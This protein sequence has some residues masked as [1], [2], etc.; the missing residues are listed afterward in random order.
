MALVISC[1]NGNAQNGIVGSRVRWTCTDCRVRF[2]HLSP[3][4]GPAGYYE[5]KH[6]GGRYAEEYWGTEATASNHQCLHLDI[7]LSE[8]VSSYIKEV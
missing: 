4:R 2:E 7:N 1:T 8:L 5:S 3:T 6:P